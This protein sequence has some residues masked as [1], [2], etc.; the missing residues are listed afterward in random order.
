MATITPM[1]NATASPTAV[2]TPGPRQ[3]FSS[4]VWDTNHVTIT[5]TN[6]GEPIAVVAWINDPSN[7]ATVSVGAHQ[8]VPVSTPAIQAQ[9]GQIVKFG[10][11]ATQ[12]G[13]AI[14]S[15]SATITVNL[16][17]TPTALPAETVTISGYVTDA[18]NN[19]VAGATVTFHSVTYEKAYPSVTTGNDGFY[20]SPR[21]Y[22]DVYTI[23]VSAGGYQPV[24]LTTNG[25][26]TEDSTVAPIPLKALAGTPTPTPTPSPTPTNPIDSW[27]SLLYNPAL[28]VGT[29]SSLI[30][31][32]AGS[33]GIYEWMERK[34]KEREGMAGGKKDE[35]PKPPKI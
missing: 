15:Y 35:G 3:V 21:M 29:I 2:P 16:G 6:N 25:K 20:T 34:R 14:D 5:V 26:I 23:S 27:I 22:P 7:K 4:P 30:A 1:P 17:P 32:V 19:P 31:V 13:T 24:S 12:N 33:I 8:T 9:N 10:F 28:C 18:N 11:D